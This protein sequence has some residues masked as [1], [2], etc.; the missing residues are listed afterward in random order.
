MTVI[1]LRC[2]GRQKPKVWGANGCERRVLGALATESLPAHNGNYREHKTLY[3]F[4]E[5][6]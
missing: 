2:W 4:C 1:E 3:N 6:R 5:R